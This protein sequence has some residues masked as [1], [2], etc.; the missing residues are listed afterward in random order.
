MFKSKYQKIKVPRFYL[1]FTNFYKYILH[2]FL[3]LFAFSLKA[4]N[5]ISFNNLTVE[6]GLSQN[7]VM[8]V[9][10]DSI[11]FIWLGTRDGLNRYDGN[12]F[13]VYK[14]DPKNLKTIIA[15]EITTIATDARGTIWIGTTNGLC[16]YDKKND[17]FIQPNKF[18]KVLVETIQMDAE[19]N[20]W[21]GTRMGIFI[22]SEKENYTKPLHYSLGN[23]AANN[24]FAIYS[25]KNTIWVGTWTGLYCLMKKG[26]T[27]QKQKISLPKEISENISAIA[28]EKN[29]DLWIG[30]ANGLA[31]YTPSKKTFKTF[32]HNHKSNSLIHNDIREL[33]FDKKGTFWIGTQA[34]L[35]ILNTKTLF[36][37]NYQNDPE[38]EKSLSFNSIH[39]IFQDRD[40]NIW[41]G[42]YFG[43]VN[44]SHPLSSTF[45][46]YR[47]SKSQTSI[48]SS[49]IS[50][51]IEDKNKNLWIGTE[52][53]GLNYFNK[54]NQTFQSYTNDP[55]SPTS[56]SSNI[57]K[58]IC[59][60]PNGSDNLFIGTNGGGL[61]YFSALTKQFDHIININSSGKKNFSE[62]LALSFDKNGRLWIGNLNGLSYLE[63]KNGKYL[64]QTKRS[65]LDKYLKNK[66]VLSLYS[67]TKNNLWIGT[68]GGLFKY[69]LD[70]KVFASYKKGQN[71]PN[72]LYS[73]YINC[74]T[75]SE[76]GF[77][78]IGTRQ[79]ISIY[80]LLKQT[81]KTYLQ[82]DG[83]INNNVV[84]I[85]EDKHQ[86][87]WIS[88]TNGL[89]ELNLKTQQFRN[90][91]KS[92]GLAGNEFNGRSF[93]KD[94]SGQIFL[95]GIKGLT[96]FYPEDIQINKFTSPLVFSGL[97]LFN[98]QV[99]V[100]G[101]DNLL[102]ENIHSV[103]QINFNYNQN[104]FTID[105]AL[106]NYVKSDKNKYAYKLEGFDRNWNYTN[107]SQA[108]YSNLPWGTYTF[109]VK[110]FNNDGIPGL[111]FISKKITIKPPLWATWWAY[112][113]YLA[114]FCFILFLIVRY[115]FLKALL[116]KTEEVQQMK[117]S[118]FTNVSHEIRT[119]LTL[120]FGSLER[121]IKNS[122]KTPEINEQVISIKNNADR[123][124][125][126]VNELMEFRKT[127]T[128]N[129][130]LNLINQDIVFFLKEI[131]NSFKHLAE[132]RGINYEFRSD[133]TE[134]I[135]S[136]D[137]WQMEKVF[138]NLLSNAF[139]FT[140]NDGKITLQIKKENQKI[141]IM[142]LDNG[143]G[144]PKSAQAELF[145]DFFQV[146][147]PS[148][149]HIGSGIGLA[150]SRSIV[151]A[152][153]GEILLESIPETREN[154]GETCFT[155][156]LSEKTSNLT[157]ENF[158]VDSSYVKNLYLPP[159]S[160]PNI[161]ASNT[162]NAKQNETILI[163]EDNL[164]IRQ[165]LDSLIST[166]YSV[167]TCDNGLTGWEM[168][169]EQLPDLIIC[170]IMMP[171][172]NGLELCKKIK[173]DER[174]AHIP[175]I[176]LTAKS[177]HEQ[178]VSGLSTGA[179]SYITKPFSLELLSL[180]VNNLI[181]SR[182]I[183]RK[184]FKES[185]GIEPVESSLSEVDQNFI[186][187][188]TNLIENKISD[189]F[190]GVP[191]L[192]KEI[193]ISQPVLY[194]KIRALTDLSV[195]DFIKTVKLK[196]ALKLL[197]EQVHSV[198]E[199]AFLVG[200]NDPKYFSREFK[201]QYGQTPKSYSM[202]RK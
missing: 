71:N 144:I 30:S 79:G 121:L 18:P 195:N 63:K 158:V 164:E 73:D 52:G 95:G 135:I 19:N 124:L 156:V 7:S 170:D 35:S 173:T 94:S 129:L 6:N 103:K 150:L 184:K 40:Q 102:A 114:I 48:R 118:F 180:N 74:I 127:E 194:K 133:T 24:V 175:F 67:D 76:N 84:G 57:I 12:T 183:T 109:L 3:L 125:R 117:L 58:V 25:Y 112:S 171:I 8:A 65:F 38:N 119:P 53:G 36:F 68:N 85:V 168:A 113:L 106:L 72:K 134:E 45:K 179:D 80:N 155:V 186:L 23:S 43:G 33:F 62:V 20:I 15:G 89:S 202:N 50:S 165:L 56:I 120:I 178:K 190:F 17:V 185:T 82:K 161:T 88:T 191:E 42:T 4:Q 64:Q 153:G 13:K 77:I 176:L 100:N 131:F 21:V 199:I 145:R 44:I 110:A 147:M 143:V 5:P 139:K 200:F 27:Y 99:N 151:Q 177:S 22:Y 2:L 154:K 159:I 26:N 116:K 46:V 148:S 96:S 66:Q 87:L 28:Q 167:I 70:T 31:R 54:K 149:Q 163:V 137:K 111:H 47:E 136:F 32:H 128:G 181:Q 1:Y 49:V 93:F 172:M 101:P 14:S 160:T 41:I 122:S 141:K 146:D 123:L 104:H 37:T 10:Q 97:H 39:H 196:K 9:A 201:K 108:S 132:S 16:Q 166:N 75:E 197:Q 188:I 157:K 98:K 187:K 189:D 34:G 59:K 11:G 152:H 182:K 126:L 78:L 138:F 169:V 107:A 86:N 60:E 142:V 105:F 198:S 81:F 91:T 29:G 61:N 92:D 130:K 193:G 162:Q 140:K 83:L 192:A 90:Y 69:N 55:A 115:F 174:T 51:I